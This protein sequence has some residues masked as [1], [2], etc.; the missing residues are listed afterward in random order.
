KPIYIGFSILDLS[1]TVIYDFFYDFI[2]VKF[3]PNASLLYTDTDSLIL[4]VITDDF[5]RVISENADKFDT[6]NYE[7]RNIFNIEKSRSV[8]GKMKDEFPGDPITCFYGTGAKAYYVS[9]LN[10]ELKKAK[11]IK[12]KV[13]QNQLHLEDYQKI[14]ERGGLILRRMKTF[15]SNR[16]DIYT[17]IINKIALSHNDDKRFIVPS[18]TKTLPWGHSDIEFYKSDVSEN[19]NLLVKVMQ[20]FLPENI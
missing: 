7:E 10:N 19:L 8:V 9:S 5:Y 3:G 4:K 6:S 1:K 11:G 14:V 12:K 17:E 15:R 13:I 18:T 20:S 2:K 16:H